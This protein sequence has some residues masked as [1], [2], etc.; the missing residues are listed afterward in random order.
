VFSK[1]RELFRSTIM[2]SKLG[3]Y[4]EVLYCVR[5]LEKNFEVS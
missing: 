4:Y 1:F 3:K 5:S 2:P